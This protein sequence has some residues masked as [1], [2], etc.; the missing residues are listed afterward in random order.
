MATIST[1]LASRAGLDIQNGYS[2]A[3]GGGDAWTNTGQEYLIFRCSAGN[4]P[5]VVTPTVQRTVDGLAVTPKTA[6]VP[7]GQELI[8]GPFPLGRYNDAN[9]LAHCT[10]ASATGLSVMVVKC[11]PA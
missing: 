11:N 6:T 7:D 5:I 1:Q 10:Y 8:V 4:G 3:S 9:G 2:A